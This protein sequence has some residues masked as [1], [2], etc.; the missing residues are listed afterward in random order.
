MTGSPTVVAGSRAPFHL[1]LA[2]QDLVQ[3]LRSELTRGQPLPARRA[4]RV[5]ITLNQATSR[6][7]HLLGLISARLNDPPGAAV[8]IAR[9][10]CFSI[11]DSGLQLDLG[12][13]H[14]N[15]GK[16]DL[17]ATATR[18]A[19]ALKPDQP[20]AHH[21]RG[22]AFQNRERLRDAVTSY[23]RVLA[24][25]A[26]QL[27]TRRNLAMALSTLDDHAPAIAH[28]LRLVGEAPHRFDFLDNLGHVLL[29]AGKTE[30]SAEVIS[31]S[32]L[33][34][35][36]PH[37]GGLPTATGL[38]IT[39]TKLR[40]DIEQLDHLLN[41]G[42]APPPLRR[43]RQT[44]AEILAGLGQGVAAAQPLEPTASQKGALRGWFGRRYARCQAPRMPGGALNPALDFEEIERRYLNSAPELTVIDNLL[45]PD[46]LVALR[47]F[48]HENSF[49]IR[50]Y[51]GGY[52]GAFMEDGFFCPLLAQVADELRAGMSNVLS[53]HLLKKAWG[54]KYD[55]GLTGINMHADFAAVNVN[56]WITPDESNLDPAGGGLVIWDK[57]APLDWGFAE[58][59]ASPDR[60]RAF[61]RNAGA[62]PII[63]PH[64]C[65]RAVIFNSNL[66]HETDK[67]MFKPGYT[68]RR[69][70]ITLLYGFRS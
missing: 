69:V 56:F 2:I 49:W 68:N 35:H 3:S 22:Y 57:P 1:T 44:Y 39:P 43:L 67:L 41:R 66:F 14:F 8:L 52:L 32:A 9:A 36:G 12:V 31:I 17:A 60:A 51:G 19:I 4:G 53:P 16:L 18:R 38:A 54:F 42:L 59:N 6:D 30:K 63:V 11:E 34:R 29:N 27:D 15:A 64:R 10:A 21:N 46:T 55:S 13:A 62:R 70:N 28:M 61:L 48:S 37:Q 24:I 47:R 5:L 25:A 50:S 45:R 7:F 23:G 26:D 33:L 40:H 65:N 58:Y 20:A